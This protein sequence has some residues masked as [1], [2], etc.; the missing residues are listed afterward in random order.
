MH[1]IDETAVKVI[2]RT[3][4]MRDIA[5]L[6]PANL[7][8]AEMIFT[9]T[10]NT[11]VDVSRALYAAVGAR[12]FWTDRFSWSFDDWE[13]WVERPDVAT[14]IALARGTIAGYFELEAQPN[15]DT[16]IHLVGLTPSFVGN[17]YGGYLVEQCVRRA[18][19]RGYL[20]AKEYGPTKRVTLRTSS[21]DHP[22]ALHNYLNRGFKIVKEEILYKKVPDPRIVEW[23]LP[24]NMQPAAPYTG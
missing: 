15:G 5:D 12:V 1:H 6:R 10:L 9:Q 23:P 8:N 24:S 16:E 2:D 22:N 4:E 13:T 18:W 14:W 21:L 20:W 19:H 7:P 3:L 17:G 11:S